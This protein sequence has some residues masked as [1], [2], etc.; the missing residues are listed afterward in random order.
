[1]AKHVGMA[2]CV[3][4]FPEAA[5]STALPAYNIANPN[6]ANPNAGQPWRILKSSRR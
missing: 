3:R 6:I 4:A 2:V 5:A 1:M